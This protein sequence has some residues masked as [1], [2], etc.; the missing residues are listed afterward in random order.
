MR[1]AI[2]IAADIRNAAEWDN[3]LCAELCKAA[4]MENEWNAADG[5]T[6]ESVVCSG[7]HSAECDPVVQRG[8]FGLKIGR[9]GTN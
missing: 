3:D 1:N 2:E 8:V 9:N 5:E 7:I 4:G 6:F